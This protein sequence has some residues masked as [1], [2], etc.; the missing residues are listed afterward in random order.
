[1]DMKPAVC[2]PATDYASSPL[3][4][5]FYGEGSFLAI[6]EKALLVGQQCLVLFD[7]LVFWN[8]EEKIL[9]H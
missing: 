2:P 1:M 3:S 8:Q 5:Q 4:P 6:N 7:L 9:W